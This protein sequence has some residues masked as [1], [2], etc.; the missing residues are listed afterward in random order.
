MKTA[1]IKLAPLGKEIQVRAGTSL[2]DILHDI[3]VEFPCGGKGICGRCKVK[4]LQGEVETTPLHTSRLIELGLSP[5]WRLACLSHCTSDLTV[6]VGQYETIIQADET[7]FEFT[8]GEGLGIAVDLGTT[9]LVG[10]LMDLATGKIV[11]VETALNPQ[12]R[13]GSDLISRLESAL[14]GNREEMVR[15]IRQKIGEMLKTLMIGRSESIR[16]IVI[17]GNTV[18]QHFFCNLDIASLSYYPFESPNLG[19]SCFN[20]EKMEWELSFDQACFYP[21]VG[22]FVGSDILAGIMA[23]GMHKQKEYSVLLDLGTN[24]EIV[25]GNCDRL[26]C[27]STAAGP[28]FEGAKIS[29]GML[30]TTGAISSVHYLDGKWDCRVIGNRDPQGICGSG[31]IDVIALLLE[32]GYLGEFGEILSGAGEVPLDKPVVITQK[33]IQEFQLAKSAIATGLEILMRK[34]GIGANDIARIYIAGGFGSYINL[35]NVVRTGMIDDKAEKM[36]QLGN[37]ALMGAKMF[38]FSDSSA[39]ESILSIT[40]HVNLE[41][42]P[43]FQELYVK[44]LS[45]R[46]FSGV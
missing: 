30:A 4:V 5:E 13:Y 40:D 15:L 12:S 25:V 7:T 26:L 33:D 35:D 45:F 42:E 8:P 11:S 32:H 21:S 39:P 43:D 10:Q 14:S 44:N 41:S 31:L 23:T 34:L 6:E 38:L 29:M 18:M 24:G 28:A 16:K 46:G 1:S 2:I 27:A 36:H 3:G 22:S 17:V 9:T 19:I 37:S 20:A